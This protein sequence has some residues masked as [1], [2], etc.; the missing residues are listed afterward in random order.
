MYISLYVYRFRR[1]YITED[2]YV[3]GQLNVM[4]PQ[5]CFLTASLQ[6]LQ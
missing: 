4:Y 6:E 3:K 2:T 1:V 5:G